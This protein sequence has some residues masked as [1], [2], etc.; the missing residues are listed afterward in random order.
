LRS[1]GQGYP[2]SEKKVSKDISDTYYIYIII[3]PLWL[4]ILSLF[5]RIN[6]IT[7]ELK[8]KSGWSENGGYCCPCPLISGTFLNK[9]HIT[10]K[11][12]GTILVFCCCCPSIFSLTSPPPLHP[13]SQTK[14]T[15]YT[16][17]VCLRR[18]DELCCRPYSAGILHSVSD[19]IQNL[20]NCFTTPIKMTSEDNINGLVSLKF[21]RPCFK[22]TQPLTYLSKLKQPLT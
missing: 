5:G 6:D 2:E 19:Q 9:T 20:P 1:T 3:L 21:L 11:F 17:S 16:D 7:D 10:S 18:G 22:L 4:Q 12:L 15:V 13:P 14:C 8:K